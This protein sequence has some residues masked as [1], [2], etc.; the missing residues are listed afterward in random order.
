VSTQDGMVATLLAHEPEL[1][2]AGVHALSLFGSVARG[3][4]RPESDVDV[5]VRLD[6]EAHLGLFRFVGLEQR[7]TELLGRP[8]QLLHEPIENLRLRANVER[9]RRRVF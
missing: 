6:P 5:A 4:D 2:A 9:D 1:R 3:D 7:L 8:V